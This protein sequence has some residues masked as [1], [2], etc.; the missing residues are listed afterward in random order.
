MELKCGSATPIYAQHD[1]ALSSRTGHGASYGVG[2]FDV[3]LS[4]ERRRRDEHYQSRA[5][6]EEQRALLPM[7]LALARLAA[8]RSYRPMMRG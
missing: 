1:Q 6:T 8:K 3:L 5:L 4:D 2:R 7:A